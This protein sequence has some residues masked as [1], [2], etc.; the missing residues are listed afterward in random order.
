MH[1]QASPRI[2]KMLPYRVRA[3]SQ[4]V[5]LNFE[6]LS[7]FLYTFKFILYFTCLLSWSY[8]YMIVIYFPDF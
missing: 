7:T 6:A 4:K 3:V 2:L 5:V 8:E 1:H